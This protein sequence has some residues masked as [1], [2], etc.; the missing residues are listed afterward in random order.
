VPGLDGSVVIVRRD[1]ANELH[2]ICEFLAN[3]SEHAANDVQRKFLTECIESIQTGDLG[4]Y[5]QSQKTW[6]LDKQPRIE[7]IFGFVES[8]R[9]PHGVRAKFEGLVAISDPSET[10][11]LLQLVEDSGKYIQ[12]LPWADG[13]MDVKEGKGP[14]EKALFEPPDFSSI[15][16]KYQLKF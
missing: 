15:H 8:Y 3:A 2:H 11:F 4:S 9:D 13:K 7:N 1:H 16:C 12:K 14:F 5:R 6:I 10:R